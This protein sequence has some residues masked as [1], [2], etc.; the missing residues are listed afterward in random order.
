M[1][2]YHINEYV[3]QGDRVV[4][5]GECAWVNRHNGNRVRKVD[6]WK[7]VNGKATQFMEYYDTHSVLEASRR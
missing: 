1:D 7:I 4:A 6:I 2:F 3:A 5:I